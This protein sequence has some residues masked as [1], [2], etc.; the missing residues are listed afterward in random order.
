MDGIAILSGLVFVYKLL[1]KNQLKLLLGLFSV[2]IAL[3]SGLIFLVG[4]LPSGA[5]TEHL[6]SYLIVM[7][8]F[9]PILPLT[10]NLFRT[11]SSTLEES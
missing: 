1:F 4:T 3:S 11:A 8:V 5:W 7:I 2:T 6:S 9:S 10:L